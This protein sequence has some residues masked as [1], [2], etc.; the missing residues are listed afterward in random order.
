[1]K[2]SA[3]SKQ[4]I[5]KTSSIGRAIGKMIDLENW[6]KGKIAIMIIVLILPFGP[7]ALA[8]YFATKEVVRR[9][10]NKNV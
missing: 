7:L 3:H 4:E 5:T 2:E 10:R 8:L 1:M 6:S 9:K